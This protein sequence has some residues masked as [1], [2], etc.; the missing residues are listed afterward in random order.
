MVERC[1]DEVGEVGR[2]ERY[3]VEHIVGKDLL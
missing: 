1:C 3:G 2:K